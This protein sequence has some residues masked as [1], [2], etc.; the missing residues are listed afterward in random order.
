MYGGTLKGIT[1]KLDYIKSLGT[2]IIY[3][4]PIFK[5]PSNHKYDTADYTKVDKAFGGESALRELISE[6]KKRKIG[7]ILDGVFNHTG[8]DSL[9][10]NKYGNYKSIGAYQSKESKYYSW[11]E[12]QKFPD[13]YTSWWG[14]DIL[15]RINTQNSECQ[16]YFVGR[17]GIIAKYRKMGI[18]GFRLDVVDE[19]SDEFIQKIKSRLEKTECGSLLY[20]EVW[21]DASNKI[22]Y[23]MRKKYY[24]GKELDGVMNYPLRAGIISFLKNC[25]TGRLLYYLCDIINNTPKRILDMQMNLLGSHD[26]ERIITSLGGED[27]FGKTN[28]YLHKVRMNKSEYLCGRRKVM[29]AYTAIAT[30]PGLPTVYYADEVGLEGYSDPFNRRTFPWGDEDVVLLSHFR[31]LGKIRNSYKVYRR[32]EFKLIYLNDEILIFKRTSKKYDYVTVIN[33]RSEKLNLSFSKK[34]ESLILKKE[35]TDFAVAGQSSE[36]FKAI[37]NTV[38]RLK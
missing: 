22:A 7:I 37:K 11:Y 26:T 38:V 29:M 5:S 27:T 12:F 21:E 20:G 31:L 34:V 4:S 15:P 6:A 13:K 18:L 35:N 32:G 24:L 25:E 36:I 2:T 10:F 17:R 16:N 19:L 8:S 1:K 28:E 30:L 14:I 23:G 3:L 9:Y 33:N